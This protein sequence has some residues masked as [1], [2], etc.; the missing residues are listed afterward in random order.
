MRGRLSCDKASLMYGLA[1]CK[2]RVSAHEGKW[3]AYKSG[4]N[5]EVHEQVKSKGQRCNTS[6]CCTCCKG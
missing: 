2:Q 5:D 1:K 3:A 6:I 4:I